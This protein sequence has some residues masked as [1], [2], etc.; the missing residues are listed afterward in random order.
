[1]NAGGQR[2]EYKQC[3]PD[4]K[5]EKRFPKEVLKMMAA[6]AHYGKSV[7]FTMA[8]LQKSRSNA[9]TVTIG[10]CYHLILVGIF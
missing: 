6:A 3:D 10:P 5:N 7:I 1:L 9:Q 4:P 2:T 8:P